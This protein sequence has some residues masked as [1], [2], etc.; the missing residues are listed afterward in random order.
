MEK[1]D[2]AY[3]HFTEALKIDSSY[4]QA[5]QNLAIAL[6]QQNQFDETIEYFLEAVQLR[7][8]FSD[9]QNNLAKVLAILDWGTSTKQP[10]A[11]PGRSSFDR[12]IPRHTTTWHMPW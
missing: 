10:R 12:E 2:R 7:S 9:A 4:A 1:F 3:T 6:V 8:D 5:H 11:P